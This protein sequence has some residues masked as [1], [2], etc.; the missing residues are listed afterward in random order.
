MCRIV[1]ILLFCYS[2][3]VGQAQIESIYESLPNDSIE[4]MSISVHSSI[5][6]RLKTIKKESSIALAGIID[7]TNKL[8]GSYYN[9]M[10]AGFLVNGFLAKKWHLKIGTIF[11]T[12]NS[13]GQLHPTSMFESTIKDKPVFSDFRGRVSYTPHSMFNFQVG[14]DH[15]FIGEGCRSLFLSDYGKPY[16][17]GQL[18]VKFWR[19]EY[20]VLYQFFREKTINNEWFQ[21]NA[22]THY[23]S[24]N[25]TKWL[26]IGLFETVLFQPKD[27]LLNRGYEL[28]YLNPVI[29]YRPQE[30]AL[31]SSDNVIMGLGFSVK[32]KKQQLY[33]QIVMD[34]FIMK[35]FTSNRGWWGNKYGLQAG[36]KGRFS[37]GKWNYFYRT[38]INIVRPYT[39]AH[40][41]SGQNYGNQGLALAHPYGANFKE[42]LAEFKFQKNNILI[43]A[44]VN[45]AERGIDSSASISYGSNIYA[46]YLNR[47]F[48]YGNKIGQGLHLEQLKSIFTVAY[49]IHKETNLQLFIEDHLSYI[50]NPTLVQHAF[51]FGIRSQLWNDYRN[52]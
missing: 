33:G 37:I 42:L 1:F 52:Y 46:S 48:D 9:R 36:L 38:E 8:D 6:P 14:I 16:P 25:P 11:S 18:R 39:Y 34:E 23:L 41:G 45:Y 10:G 3:L 21:K 4:S 15:N 7:V 19:L 51:I 17:F 2:K 24:L 22:A 40:R 13:E 28:E 29:F 31:G 50:F 30:Y 47:P 26:N 43:K 27:T 32:R 35:E 5:L 44:F 12:A 20:L 49:Q